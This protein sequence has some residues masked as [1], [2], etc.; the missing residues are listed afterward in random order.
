MRQGPKNKWKYSI[1]G[2][3]LK[4]LMGAGCAPTFRD[5]GTADR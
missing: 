5:V 4:K 1:G 2:E 3:L